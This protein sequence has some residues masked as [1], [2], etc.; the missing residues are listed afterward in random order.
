MYKKTDELEWQQVQ[1]IIW[2]VLIS[3]AQT[4]IE[5]TCRLYLLVQACYVLVIKVVN[6]HLQLW[7]VN[8]HFKFFDTFMLYVNGNN[9]PKLYCCLNKL[10]A[11]IN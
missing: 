9:S 2:V 7:V 1:L 4:N 6:G 8:D 11:C 5:V 10:S 3:S